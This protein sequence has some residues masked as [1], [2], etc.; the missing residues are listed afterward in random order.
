[1]FWKTHNHIFYVCIHTACEYTVGPES[2]NSLLNFSLPRKLK[3]RVKIKINHHLPDQSSL[4]TTQR[5]F[6]RLIKKQKNWNITCMCVSI[7][8][9][10]C[11]L[12]VGISGAIHFF[13]SFE[14]VLSSI[15]VELHG[16]DLSFNRNPNPACVSYQSKNELCEVKRT[17][18]RAQRQ[19]CS[20]TQLSYWC[21][22]HLGQPGLFVQPN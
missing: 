20:K 15:C 10:C 9:L 22:R 19:N 18:W 2:N 11:H 8:T 12:H 5:N 17:V 1:M 3:L 21:E 6:P 16:K 13:L 14:M 7:Q 4:E